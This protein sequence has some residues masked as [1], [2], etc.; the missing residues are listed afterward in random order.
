MVKLEK[1]TQ[2]RQ[3]NELTQNLI[4]FTSTVTHQALN[5]L[6]QMHPVYFLL[7]QY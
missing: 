2:T 6:F 7:A 5:H 1:S 4:D 3:E